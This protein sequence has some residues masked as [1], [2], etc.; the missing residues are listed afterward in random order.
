MVDSLILFLILVNLI[1]DS[2][3]CNTFT[4]PI[5][6]RNLPTIFTVRLNY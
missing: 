6:V 3:K 2:T 4:G 5:R 1:A